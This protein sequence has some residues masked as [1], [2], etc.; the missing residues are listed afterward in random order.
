MLRFPRLIATPRA[1]LVLAALTA[2]AAA[3]QPIPAAAQ[4]VIISPGP[5]VR[6]FPEN[7]YCPFPIEM[8]FTATS[9]VATIHAVANIYAF[10]GA[11]P[12]Y[13][14]QAIDNIFVT[15]HAGYLAHTVP[16][17]GSYDFCYLNDQVPTIFYHDQL[18]PSTAKLAES[19]ATNAA[20]WDLTQGGYYDPTRS[21]DNDPSNQD[22]APPD[23][24][25]SGGCLG[26][27][28]DINPTPSPTDS[29]R[30]SIVVSDLT[31]GQTYNLTGW[32]IV[33]D[34]IFT[35]QAS[36]T[37]KVTGPG[38]TPITQKTWG[39]LKREYR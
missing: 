11:T 17:D 22:P 24:D 3:L 28:L 7:V 29:A 9:T 1:L 13:T 33:G 21:A 8:E 15:P 23:R 20:L 27:G 18:P 6:K 14:H 37:I 31:P 25:H 39:G 10:S 32:W 4:D 35:E 16:N 38:S 34:G 2:S 19:F 26:L 5:L 36:L 30:T 12:F